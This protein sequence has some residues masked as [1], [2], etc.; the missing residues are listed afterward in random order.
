MPPLR[1]YET[2]MPDEGRAGRGEAFGRL[3]G[4]LK[5]NRLKM[6]TPVE[7]EQGR[8]MRFFVPR[9]RKGDRFEPARDVRVV[10]LPGRTVVSAG[11]RGGY[12]PRS[13]ARGVRAAERYLAAHPEWRATGP[14]ETAYWNG[15]M[16]PPPLR[17][18]EVHVPVAPADAPSGR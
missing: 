4:F 18:F 1:A 9:R 5:E 8:A 16:V 6:T 11:L 15:P 7:V 10:D 3:F 17:R 2:P 14:P 12:G 13:T